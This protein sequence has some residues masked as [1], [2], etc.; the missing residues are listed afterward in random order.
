M[1]TN[2]AA[3]NDLAFCT[4]RPKAFKDRILSGCR[5]IEITDSGIKSRPGMKLSVN[6]VLYTPE[7]FAEGMGPF[8]LT[9]F[10]LTIR[11]RKAQI[12]LVVEDDQKSNFY[13]HFYAVYSD[14][15][16]DNLGTVT[17]SRTDYHT[18]GV[19]ISYVIFK[20]KPLT[21][22][23]I[24]FMARISYGNLIP[25]EVRVYE[26]NSDFYGWRQVI[27]DSFYTPTVLIHGRGD[28]AG[29]A[30]LETDIKLSAPRQLEP[31]NLLHPSC[32]LYYTTDG[33]SSSFTL[34]DYG[35]RDYGI[36]C[37]LTLKDHSLKS[38]YIAT[39]DDRSAA[40][41]V[42]GSSVVMRV[43][44]NLN[45]IYFET[46][47]AAAVPLAFT[48]TENNLKFTLTP[49][50]NEDALMLSSMCRS[51]N[52]AAKS[53]SGVAEV[54][55][56]YGN[57]FQP[58]T[59]VWCDPERPLYFPKS[60][61]L[62][63]STP[64]GAIAKIIDCD[65]RLLIFKQNM[66][67]SATFSAAT[68]YDLAGIVNGISL[69]GQISMPKYTDNGRIALSANVI[70]TTVK[71]YLGR[72][73]FCTEDKKIFSVTEGLRTESR[74]NFDEAPDFA[75]VLNGRYLLAAENRILI[76]CESGDSLLSWRLP[77]KMLD[78]VFFGDDTIFFAK[79]ENDALY[80]F[81][82]DADE[83]SFLKS[84]GYDLQKCEIEAVLKL[85]L[86]DE[87]RR[88]RLS[89]L[90][91]DASSPFSARLSLYNENGFIS[92]NILSE[93]RAYIHRPTVFKRLYAELKTRG[94]SEISEISLKYSKLGRI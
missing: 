93:K 8:T 80:G 22:G 65:G 46:G 62:T 54:L 69:S 88:C 16:K 24:F 36:D 10:F 68:E 91:L 44:R 45:R 73:Y 9:D 38:F 67:F 90:S 85:S 92:E 6:P 5:N 72:V 75:A 82:L 2:I 86:L 89:A 56:L 39:N 28:S 74:L 59:I 79:A 17:F 83:D 57:L 53:S 27:S 12:A 32:I 29:A 52:F 60:C 1:K 70:P 94:K 43:D 13:Y 50:N 48:A 58:D 33:Y 4:I 25:D 87:E 23:G 64:Q 66:L 77:V 3:K 49:T 51:V 61:T 19:P 14:C 11:G 34:P 18:F 26:I 55:V 81:N 21:G 78:A 42:D 37:T 41:N 71:G 40:V 63:L 7:E 31:L 76:T 20:G 30:F 35:F 84:D 15:S 47:N